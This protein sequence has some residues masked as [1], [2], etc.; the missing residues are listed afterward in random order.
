MMIYPRKRK[1]KVNLSKVAKQTLDEVMQEV[2]KFVVTNVN[3]F[4][5]VFQLFVMIF[6]CYL[7]VL[8]HDILPCIIICIVSLFFVEY[9]KKL[10]ANVQ[11]MTDEGMPVPVERF[12]EVKEG[13]YIS[14]DREE[15]SIQYLCELEDYLQRKGLLKHGES[16]PV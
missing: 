6:L 13:G 2:C 1:E 9:M 8:I 7:F 15:E 10:N 4:L 11:N 3:L 12:T 16:K 5:C 14:I